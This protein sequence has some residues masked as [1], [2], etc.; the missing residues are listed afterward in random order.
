MIQQKDI[1]RIIGEEYFPAGVS[2]NNP[3]QLF[4]DVELINEF[5]QCGDGFRI[6]YKDKSETLWFPTLAS[7]EQLAKQ[8]EQAIA[9]RNDLNL[10]VPEFISDLIAKYGTPEGDLEAM[11]K[12]L[13]KPKY[14][15]D[16]TD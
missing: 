9:F 13:N 8:K 11:R 1:H 16:G 3:D 14:I 2:K 4:V 10:V 5:S 6:I 7:D 15:E 12:E